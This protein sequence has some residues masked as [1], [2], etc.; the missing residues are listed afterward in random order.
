MASDVT[1]LI[2]RDDRE[3][4]ALFE[5]VRTGDGDRVALVR[6]ITVRLAAHARAAEQEVY[7]A[8]EEVDPSEEGD[9]EEPYNEQALV[10]HLLRKARNLTA[11]AHFDEAFAAFVAEAQR[12]AE[13]VRTQLLPALAH[14]LDEAT[15]R[16]LG[17]AFERTRT[18]LLDQLAIEQATLDASLTVLTIEGGWPADLDDATRVELYELA[19]KADIPGRSSMTKDELIEALSEQE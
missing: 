14:A 9:V 15:M 5:R 13:E 18:E 4:A 2:E 16:R 6:E 1:M 7:P 8:L 10:R 19:K 12:H 3:I 17:A 11:S